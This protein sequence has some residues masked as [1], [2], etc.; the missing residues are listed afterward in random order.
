MAVTLR[1]SGSN[2]PLVNYNNGP[3]THTQMDTNFTQF[4]IS[5]SI[6]GS[7][8]F[9]FKPYATLSAGTFEIPNNPPTGSNFNIQFKSGSAPSGAN[10]AW[11]SS[12]NLKFDFDNN[13]L[14]VTGSQKIKGDLIVDGDVHANQFVTYLSSSFLNVSGSTNFGNSFD[15]THI[16]QGLVVVSNGITGSIS[17]SVEGVKVLSLSQSIENRVTTQESFS[18]T[19]PSVYASKTQ[20][21]GSITNL[22]SSVA[23]SIV[24]S[25]ST[26]S[27]SVASTYLLKT[28]DTV[29]GNLTVTGILTA[30]QFN[31]EYVSSSIIYESGSTKFGDSSGD[32]HSFTGSV[33]VTQG[34]ISGSFIG[35]GTGLTGV[36][37]YTDGDT[38]SYINSKGVF[39]GSSQV[40]ANTITNFDSNVLSYINSKGV[41]SGSSQISHDS[42]TGFVANEHIDHSTVSIV[43]GNGL[44]G[45]GT[46]A[47]SR[48]INIGAGT[49][50]DVAADAISV[51]VSD[52]MTNGSNNRVVTA[53]GTDGQNAEANMTFDGSTLT[54]TGDIV[55]GANDSHDLG[56]SGNVWRN[57]YTGDLHLSNEAKDEGNAID[58]T[59]GNWTIQEGAEHLY[60]LNNKSGKKYKFKLEEI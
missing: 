17:G 34:T 53:T 19:V 31:T 47:A 21:T 23:T 30:Q 9:F 27:S 10:A 14:L 43:A 57:V 26:L 35:D 20:V 55:P 51:D 29:Q 50:I 44:T 7:S 8:I 22:S 59:K 52:F 32:V 5:A 16:F 37:S 41:T 48:T 49:G 60:I 40:N 15:D 36:T 58:G 18:S 13:T 56:A 2:Q 3:L 25:I 42:T 4:F 38:L 39:S 1:A 54:V 45:G 12:D 24:N 33:K 28:S 11:Y 46:I 6:S